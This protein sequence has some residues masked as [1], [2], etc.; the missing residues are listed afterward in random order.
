MIETI[1]TFALMFVVNST[2]ME[3]CKQWVG[4]EQ[5]PLDGC[6]V[7]KTKNIYI[8]NETTRPQDFVL[9][10]EIAHHL[11][12]LKFDKKLFDKE[13]MADQFAF[14]IYG[15]KYP[16]LP[17]YNQDQSLKEYFSKNCDQ[18]CVDAILSIK[19]PNSSFSFPFLVSGREEYVRPTVKMF[20]AAYG[21]A[22]DG[23]IG[24]QTKIILKREIE[25]HEELVKRLRSVKLKQ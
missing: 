11:F 7:E 12:K 1:F 8:N 13:T 2:D 21:L 20:Q 3:N 5:Y 4:P 23:L 17:D 10:H 25:V 9:Y 22:P 19:L 6:Y 16:E 18:M 15:K 24:P 14:F